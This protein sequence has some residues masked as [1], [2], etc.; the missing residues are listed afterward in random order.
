MSDHD[1]LLKTAE[2]A[3][4]LGVAKRTMEDWRLDKIGPPYVR[5]GRRLIRYRASDLAE[6]VA[7]SPDATIAGEQTAEMAG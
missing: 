1:V 2:A 3:K 7:S 6:Y 4:R 5:V